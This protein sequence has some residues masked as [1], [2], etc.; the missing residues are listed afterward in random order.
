MFA[1]KLHISPLEMW[2]MPFYDIMLL[3]RAYEEVVNEEKKNEEKQRKEY[4]EE[5]PDYRNFSNDIQ[6]QMNN[7]HMPSGTGDF[8]MP[9][10]PQMPAMPSMPSFG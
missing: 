3:Y 4:E 5:M 9:A 1:L 10:M 8:K 7:Y 2:Q 6:R